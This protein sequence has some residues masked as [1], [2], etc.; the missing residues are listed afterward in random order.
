METEKIRI[1]EAHCNKCGGERK[2]FVRAEHAVKDSD[3]FYDEYHWSTTFK[4]IECCG[5]KELSVLCEKYFSEWDGIEKIQ[6]PPK[7]S[8][9]PEWWN[10]LEDKD[11][12]QAMQEVYAASSQGL[13]MLATIGV[14]TLL[15]QAFLILLKKD[16]GNFPDQLRKMV[17]NGL[18]TEK[19][20]EI[21][22][23]IVDVGSAAAHRAY[24]P[25]HEDLLKILTATESFLYQKFILPS[26]AESVK[27]ET[28]NR[29]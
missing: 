14:R 5:C 21:F 29:K 18:L 27:K 20:K 10:R 23:S 16:H 4:I 9:K 2:S 17:E 22:Q 13:T 15:S 3:I 26:D 19:E 28:P 24:I 6:W 11:L 8:R 12:R 25:K 7:Q 1:I